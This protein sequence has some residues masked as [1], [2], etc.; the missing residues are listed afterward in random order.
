MQQERPEEQQN[1]EEQGGAEWVDTERYDQQRHQ[2]QHRGVDA[3]AD[4]ETQA[5]EDNAG[6]EGVLKPPESK[7]GRDQD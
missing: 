5:D 4:L 2:R 6:T 7:V 1:E 3:A